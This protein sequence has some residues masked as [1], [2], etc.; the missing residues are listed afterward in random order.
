M[1][2]YVGILLN[3]FRMLKDDWN[4]KFLLRFWF[5]FNKGTYP[6]FRIFSNVR[7]PDKCKLTDQ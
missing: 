6:G 1:P 5:C 2:E 7:E 4:N 3:D